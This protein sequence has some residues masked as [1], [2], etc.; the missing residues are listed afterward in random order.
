MPQIQ[1]PTYNAVGR[2]YKQ[3]SFPT[4]NHGDI[5]GIGR[6]IQAYNEMERQRQKY[7]V[8]QAV[9]SRV[10]KRPHVLN[11]RKCSSDSE[12]NDGVI[13]VTGRRDVTAEN[14]LTGY[15]SRQPLACSVPHTVEGGVTRGTQRLSVG[16]SRNQLQTIKVL[17]ISE[18]RIGFTMRSNLFL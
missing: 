17:G 10:T 9:Y 5:T 14:R 12:R 16:L 8:G 6:G 11:N 7:R 15:A 1:I 13:N 18:L 2:P 4:Y 3:P